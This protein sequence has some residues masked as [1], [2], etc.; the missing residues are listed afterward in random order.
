M[1]PAYVAFEGEHRIGAGDLKEVARAAKQ[2][3][4][5]RKDAAILVFN[6]RTSALV[7][8]DFRGSV[9]DV[10]A[11]LPKLAPPLDEEPATPAGPRGPGRPKLGVV[12][13]EITLLPRHWD[14]LAQQKGG[15]SVVIRKLIDE[16][17]RASGDKDRTRIA[18]DAAYRFMT[19]M[20]G[21]RPNYE[22]AIRAL[23]AHDRRRFA[24]LIADWPAD[25]RDHT[26]GLAYSD[27]AD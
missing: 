20:A 16:A 9:E 4:D 14:W 1:N 15:A 10:L 13:R 18:Q 17:R 3:L 11:R 5:R 24:T 26:I 23:F 2:L 22:D 27:Q 12:A 21:N 7:D 6:G 8:I 19:T 25:I